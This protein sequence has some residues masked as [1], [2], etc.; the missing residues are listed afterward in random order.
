MSEKVSLQSD[1]QNKILH[2]LK[3]SQSEYLSFELR[4]DFI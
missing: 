4:V 2:K 3:R 1:M